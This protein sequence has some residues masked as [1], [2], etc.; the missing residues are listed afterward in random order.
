MYFE[1]IRQWAADR[2]LIEGSN[3]Q[4]QITKTVEEMGELARGIARSDMEKIEDG[5]GDTVVTLTIIAAQ[6][7]LKIEDCIASAYSVIAT[8]TGRMENGV[9]IKD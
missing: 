9:F 2:N 1:K 8:R 4:A 5:L 6:Y 3:P 7:G